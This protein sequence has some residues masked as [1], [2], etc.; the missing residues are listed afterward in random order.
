MHSL[1]RRKHWMLVVTASLSTTY[2]GALGDL[3]A[4]TTLSRTTL[5]TSQARTMVSSLFLHDNI[6]T[7]FNLLLT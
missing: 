4:T 7:G 3:E 2:L 6:T 5:P 1:G